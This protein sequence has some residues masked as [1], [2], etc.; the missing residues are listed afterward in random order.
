MLRESAQG[1]TTTRSFRFAVCGP[2]RL[3]R[4]ALTDHARKVED[5]GFGTIFISEHVGDQHSPVP[6]MMAA[7]LATTKLRVGS[8]VFNCDHHNAVRL[9]QEIASIDILTEGRLEVGLGA[10][11]Y[12][13]DYQLTGTSFRSAAERIDHLARTASALDELLAPD[14]R[15]ASPPDSTD[16]VEIA[17]ARL[18]L[19]PVQ[20]PKVP[21]LIGGGGRRVL[22]VA[23]LYADIVDLAP[24][25]PWPGR[26]D[27]TSVTAAATSAKLAWLREAAP[28]RV[29]THELSVYPAIAPPQVTKRAKQEIEQLSA[30]IRNRYPGPPLNSVD[31]IN[32]PHILIGSENSLIE[33]LIELPRTI[34]DILSTSTARVGR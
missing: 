26:L 5:L 16:R 15:T 29:G 10:G 20:R 3:D 23:A 14:S 19:K 6:A 2:L 7:A 22:S 33:K 24:R 28:E 13:P 18:T 21:L 1:S 25:R 27:L 11:W 30:R 31:I 32:S 9:A 8:L 34:R 4:R 17:A 12:Q